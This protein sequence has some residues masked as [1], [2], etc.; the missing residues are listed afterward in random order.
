MSFIA[1]FYLYYQE[2][3]EVKIKA[4]HQFCL[5]NWAWAQNIL[6]LLLKAKNNESKV[7]KQKTELAQNSNLLK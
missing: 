3:T 7:K 2:V 6:N 5:S 4:G 1:M